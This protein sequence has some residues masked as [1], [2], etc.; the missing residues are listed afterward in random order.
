MRG[1]LHAVVAR[2]GAGEEQRER[3]APGLVSRSSTV[4]RS[5]LA[6]AST[7][8]SLVRVVSTPTAGTP[9]R[10]R[11]PRRSP[12]RNRA[13]AP[14]LRRHGARDDDARPPAASSL[15][16]CSSTSCAREQPPQR[17]VAAEH[18]VARRAGGRGRRSVS[19]SRAPRAPGARRA[20]FAAQAGRSAASARGRAAARRRP[21]RSSAFSTCD[22]HPAVDRAGEDE[23]DA[24][25]R[26]AG[27][28][29][30]PG[31]RPATNACA[32]RCVRARS[33]ARFVAESS[34]LF[35]SAIRSL[36]S[37]RSL[38][39]DEALPGDPDPDEDAD[40]QR[41]EDGRQRGD[42]VAKVEH[43][44]EARRSLAERVEPVQRPARQRAAVARSATAP[45]P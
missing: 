2:V 5:C 33:V 29:S 10:G 43:R 32:A 31:R 12:A 16:D 17:A 42:V 25:A 1:L 36:S 24:L 39:R 30:A 27:R 14:A 11:A 44:L 37:E 38:S 15:P 45:R 40:D 35:R 6:N 18:E 19:G 28:P 9:A 13:V 22:A 7:A 23:R 34:R 4:E 20:R 8:E 26:R 41:E 21:R 3:E